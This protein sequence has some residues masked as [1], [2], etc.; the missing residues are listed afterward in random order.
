MRWTRESQGLPLRGVKPSRALRP[1]PAIL[2]F[3][4]RTVTISS[5]IDPIAREVEVGL[6]GIWRRGAARVAAQESGGS[7]VL[8]IKWVGCEIARED[9]IGRK[10][11]MVVAAVKERSTGIAVA[12]GA[13]AI[14]LS[15]CGC[16][17]HQCRQS[18]NQQASAWP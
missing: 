14:I 7:A 13:L 3:R 17:G 5:T 4:C 2:I 11:A 15:R 12:Q 6:G 8:R 16:C 10:V 1:V 9:A 18:R